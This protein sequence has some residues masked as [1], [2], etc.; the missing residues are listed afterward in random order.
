MVSLGVKD[1]APDA[2][3]AYFLEAHSVKVRVYGFAWH[4]TSKTPL[5]DFINFLH[6]SS[7]R[8]LDFQ[9][10]AVSPL[11]GRD[12][13]FG[14][15]LLTIKDQRAYTLLTRTTGGFEVTPRQLETN[16]NP[17][18][19]NFFIINA[20]TGRGLY[21]YYHH[22]ASLSNFG[23][24]SGHRFLSYKSLYDI[25]RGR[26]KQTVLLR[27]SNFE[28]Y[29]N[30][31]ERIKVIEFEANTYTP[32][33]PLFR[34]LTDKA[35]RVRHRLVF[36][37][38][39]QRDHK[40]LKEDLIGLLKKETFKFARVEGQDEDG[41]DAVYKLMNDPDALEETEYDDY[42]RTVTINAA[43]F[44]KTINTSANIKK[45]LRLYDDEKVVNRL[46]TVEEA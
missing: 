21:Q 17:V 29:V 38:R 8:T 9:I 11:R 27:Q 25:K 12:G 37:T 45:L 46:M 36:F 13:M 14:G 19:V 43:D 28:E 20:Q 33:R 3:Q 35:N 23:N 1:C 6:E 10:M 2:V 31:L 5:I 40:S 24:F 34:A 32:N 39:H 15:I 42:V 26:L 18:D 4:L 41:L 7:D 22:S 16:T 30:K 44:D